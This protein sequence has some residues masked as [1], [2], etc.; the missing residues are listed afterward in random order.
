MPLRADITLGLD[1]RRPVHDHRVAGAAVVPGH[2]L[3]PGERRVGGDRPGRGEVREG[4][5]AAPIIR[6]LQHALGGLGVEDAVEVHQLVVG[7][8]QAAFAAR[9]VVAH[10]VDEQGVV[11]SANIVDGAHQ[12]ADLDV[13]VL[14]EAGKGFHLQGVERLLVVA[15]LLPVLDVVRHGRQLGVLGDDAHLF[16]AGEGL[17]AVLQPAGIELA[18]V[19]FDELLRGVVRGV[20]R[21]R[22][23]VDEERLVRRHRLLELHPRDGLI[24]HVGCEVIIRV[25]LLGYSGYTVKNHRVPLV[26]LATDEA[27][28]LVEARVRRPAIEGAGHG[29]L[30][31]RGLVPLAERRR[32]V[33]VEA[34]GLGEVLASGGALALVAGE[35]GGD[36]HHAA[37][38]DLVV[39]PPGQQR[40]TRRRA[41]CRGV[42]MVE[43]QP[44]VG[45]LI[46]GR[47]L[48]AAAEAGDCAEADVIDQHD[49]DVR[50]AF[51]RRD[52]EPRGLLGV[53]GVEHRDGHTIRRVDRE[54][55]SVQ[56]LCRHGGRKTGQHQQR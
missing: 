37:D 35:A 10:D 7:A 42:E 41:E 39:V 48:D 2:L 9:T 32:A 43:A 50:G 17:L 29:G 36:L 5:G 40:R 22:R 16:L 46:E 12:P 38:V 8:G 30:P 45:Q 4:V 33:A 24:G 15:E 6:A 52:L 25:V 1:D 19:L 51:R 56:F 27:V 11:Q 54:N 23:E 31:G 13:R 55:G 49:D 28:E 18:L 34:Q 14:H 53:P 47:R 26:G 3:G 20:H 44:F 21:T